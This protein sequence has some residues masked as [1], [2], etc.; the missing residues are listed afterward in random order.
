MISI[1]YLSLSDNRLPA[2]TYAS[3]F[4]RMAVTPDTAIISYSYVHDQYDL[5][6]ILNID[7]TLEGLRSALLILLRILVNKAMRG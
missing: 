2:L 5:T 3:K 4:D 6:L 1:S 7:K